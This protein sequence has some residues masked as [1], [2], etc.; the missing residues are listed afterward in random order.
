MKTKKQLALQI[1]A[2]LLSLLMLFTACDLSPNDN[3]ETTTQGEEV[4]THDGSE[5]T[6]PEGD[7]SSTPDEGV[8]TTS[9]DEESST[10]GGEDTPAPL[11]VPALT[12]PVFDLSSIPAYTDTATHVLN[13]NVPYFTENQYTTTSYEYYTPL[14]SLGRCGVVVACLGQDL[15]PTDNRGSIGHIYPTG[16]QTYTSAD[17][18][19]NNFYERSHLIGFQLSGEDAN[20]SNLISGTYNLNGVMQYYEDM[21]ANY[22]NTT[23][24]HVLYRVTPIFEG[25][26]LLASGVHMEA[27]S[28]E[29]NGTGISF[30]IYIYNVQTDYDIDYATGEFELSEDALIANATFVINKRNKKF[31]E[32][33]CSSV[34]DM[35]ESNKE[36]TTKTYEELIAE[37][38]VPCGS[39]K[40]GQ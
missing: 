10:D 33:D 5:S 31:H 25:N 3:S 30:N 16:W 26:N 21:V 35:K 19:K 27:Y 20:R 8:T 32:V 13:G 38:Y 11:E 36:Y 15:M 22:I 9:G 37:G 39:C 4:P 18:E 1:F 23:N 12:K 7:E 24:N 34:L 2:L 29:D 14:D 17:G 28:V 6:T 40:P